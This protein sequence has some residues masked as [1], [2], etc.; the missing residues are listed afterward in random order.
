[1]HGRFISAARAQLNTCSRLSQAGRHDEA[2]AAA[3]EVEGAITSSLLPEAQRLAAAGDESAALM[4]KEVRVLQCAALLA[5]AHAMPAQSKEPHAS[6]ESLY[7]EAK[8]VAETHLPAIHPMVA[9]TQSLCNERQLAAS[10]RAGVTLPVLSPKSGRHNPGSPAKSSSSSPHAR[11]KAL[12]DSLLERKADEQG[13]HASSPSHRDNSE[14]LSTAEDETAVVHSE[15]GSKGISHSR[16]TPPMSDAGSSY[17]ADHH[18]DEHHHFEH[19]EHRLPRNIFAE[20]IQDYQ[21]EQE[22]NKPWF[23]NRQDDV[24]KHVFEKARFARLQD[25]GRTDELTSALTSSKFT[26]VGHK[27]QLKELHKCNLTRSEPALLQQVKMAGIASPE[28]FETSKLRLQLDP[29]SKPMACA[30]RSRK[31]LAMS[32]HAF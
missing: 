30:K 2:S 3:A 20:Y 15:K 4:M 9:L 12:A 1:M 13:H 7:E 5:R 6:C 21:L 23:N 32:A 11:P 19:D 8:V 18:D 29:T 28:A 17:G 25:K 27:I 14:M 24:R 22:M 26:A 31:T 10:G 16:R